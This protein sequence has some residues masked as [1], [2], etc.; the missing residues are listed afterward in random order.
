MLQSAASQDDGRK[1]AI[2]STM[3]F[4]SNGRVLANMIY[5][6]VLERFP[7]LKLVSVDGPDQRARSATGCRHD[8]EDPAGQRRP[9][10]QHRYLSG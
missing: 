4:M 1:L 8:A 3:M 9:G 7:K 2:G 5:S 10:L 6:L